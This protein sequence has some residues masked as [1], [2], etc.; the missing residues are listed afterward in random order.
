MSIYA[1]NQPTSIVEI[2]QADARLTELGLSKLLLLEVVQKTI[3]ERSFVTATHPKGYFGSVSY[4]EGNRFLRDILVATGLWEVDTSQHLEGVRNI[5]GSIRILFQNVYK[6]CDPLVN[7]KALSEKGNGSVNVC[8]GNE[9]EFYQLSLQLGIHPP[10]NE[11]LTQVDQT[12]QQVFYL[13]LDAQ[14]AAELS[15]PTISKTALKFD[16]FL[17]RI[18]LRQAGELLTLEATTP[19][20]NESDATEFEEKLNEMV[21]PRKA[22]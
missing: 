16:F 1:L 11:N 6:A 13:M 7:P 2:D 21:T 22:I 20:L 3:T 9:Q 12:Q 15:K 19:L 4:N 17:E 8:K 18:F 5:D 10:V 14:G